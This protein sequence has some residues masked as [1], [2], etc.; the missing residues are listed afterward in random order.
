MM[1]IETDRLLLRNWEAADAEAFHRLNSDEAVMRFFSIR[2]SREEADDF[3]SRLRAENAA[4]GYGFI[5]VTSRQTGQC[6]GMAGLK[7]T[8]DVPVR[9]PEVVE[10]GWRLVPEFWGAGYATEAAQALL[11]YGFETL[12]LSEIVSFAVWNNKPSIAVMRR[13]GMKC[14]DGGDFDHPLVANDHPHLK[15]HVLYTLARGDWVSAPPH[16]RSTLNPS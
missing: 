2:R 4:R 7:P 13:I 3:L 9:Q 11:A 16:D 15:R 6:I 12:G 14:V 10:I 1:R 8:R 5:A